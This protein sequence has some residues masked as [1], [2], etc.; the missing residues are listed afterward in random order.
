MRRFDSGCSKETLR[1]RE[2]G[3]RGGSCAAFAHIFFSVI[4]DDDL[5]ARIMG[6]RDATLAIK[7]MD[8]PVGISDTGEMRTVMGHTDHSGV[9]AAG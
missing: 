9:M 2:E 5:L 6:S 4:L 7:G 1:K 8:Q 3:G